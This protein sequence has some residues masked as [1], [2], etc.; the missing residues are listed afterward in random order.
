M[1][2]TLSLF[3]LAHPPP[4]VAAIATALQQRPVNLIQGPPGTGKTRTILGLLSVLLQST[5]AP[6]GSAAQA[7][8]EASRAAASAKGLVVFRQPM[9][10]EEKHKHWC[11]HHT[12]LEGLKARV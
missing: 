5:A 9:K 6:P 11:V 8:A 10:E 2:K 4:Q 1:S 7:E 3:R 12:T